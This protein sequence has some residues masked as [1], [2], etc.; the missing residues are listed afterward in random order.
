MTALSN[1]SVY[2]AVRQIPLFKEQETP[3]AEPVATMPQILQHPEEA[4]VGTLLMFWDWL[5]TKTT[6]LSREMQDWGIAHEARKAAKL[7]KH[8]ASLSAAGRRQEFAKKRRCGCG[9]CSKCS[10]CKHIMADMGL[11]GTRVG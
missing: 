5:N 7:Q 2:P 1:T 10:H 6:K 11:L 8:Y 3:A 4:A 9:G